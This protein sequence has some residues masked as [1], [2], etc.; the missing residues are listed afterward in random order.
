MYLRE[1][2]VRVNSRC[3][4]CVSKCLVSFSTVTQSVGILVMLRLIICRKSLNILPL[5][6]PLWET[7]E[8]NDGGGGNLGK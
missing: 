7:E 6:R 3:D 5:Q 1:N 4:T 2:G 8:N